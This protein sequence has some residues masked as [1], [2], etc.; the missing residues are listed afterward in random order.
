MVFNKKPRPRIGLALGG[1]AARGLAHLGVIQV[2]KEEK[3]P[4]DFVA[5]VSVGSIVAAGLAAGLSVEQ[6]GRQAELVNWKDLGRW[7]LSLKG[8]NRNDRMA[9]WLERVLPVRTFEELEI[10]L[11]I[12]A[13]DLQTGHPVVLESGP[14]FPAIRASCAIPGLYV[15]VEWQG[16]LLADGYL[17]CNLPVQQ[18]REMGANRVIASAIG[19]EVSDRIKLNNVYQILLRSFS[20][21]SAA[22][23]RHS[24]PQADVLIRPRIENFSWT[25]LHAAEELIQAGELAART[26]VE[27]LREMLPSSRWQR[28]RRRLTRRRR[29]APTRTD[30]RVR[31][32]AAAVTQR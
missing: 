23:Q 11:R 22:A 9:T 3:I 27:A 10:P 8:F 1:G 25:D 16:R 26:Q 32:R 29:A 2:L 18:V 5:G 15:P 14:L 30:R 6:L 17:T 28:L 31:L 7:S 19:L 12:V 13:T 24:M 21:M 4:I 20:I